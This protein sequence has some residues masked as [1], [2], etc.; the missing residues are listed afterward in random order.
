[1]FTFG[2]RE[3][4]R[5]MRSPFRR[6]RLLTSPLPRPLPPAS[7]ARSPL[8]DVEGATR[9]PPQAPKRGR[10]GA[11]HLIAALAARAHTRSR[12]L[13]GRGAAAAAGSRRRRWAPA[14]RSGA[15]RAR[16]SPRIGGPLMAEGRDVLAQGC[17]GTRRPRVRAVRRRVGRA[18]SPAGGARA[19]DEQRAAQRPRRRARGAPRLGR[20]RPRQTRGGGARAASS[21]PP[22]ASTQRPAARRARTPRAHVIARF[23]R[24]TCPPSRPPT[25]NAKRGAAAVE[26]VAQ[27]D[28]AA[29]AVDTSVEA[30]VA[31]ARR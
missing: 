29:R 3:W 6:P 14:P 8:G 15:R 22:T 17:A 19:R 16:S 21:S 23:L 7:R 11:G 24:P 12:D 30:S 20:A 9:A 28:S 31:E 2:P 25:P 1:M 13:G 18:T 27:F 4:A 26:E 5:T 10:R